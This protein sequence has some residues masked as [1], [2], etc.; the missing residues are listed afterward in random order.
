[1]NLSLFHRRIFRW[2]GRCLSD[3]PTR[4]DR[5]GFVERRVLLLLL[6]DVTAFV[7]KCPAARGT[8]DVVVVDVSVVKLV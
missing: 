1:M 2:D 6:G 8:L 7:S 5:V 4:R 3:S